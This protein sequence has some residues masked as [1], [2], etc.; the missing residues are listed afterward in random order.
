MN[1]RQTLA[2]RLAGQRLARQA[3]LRRLVTRPPRR[4]NPLGVF[5]CAA[6][7]CLLFASLALAGRGWH[8]PAPT[9]THPAPANAGHPAARLVVVTATHAPLES[10]DLRRVCTHTPAGRLH[11]RFEPG[12]RS[13][14]RGYLAEGETIWLDD[15]S[16]P[17]SLR[18]GSQWLHLAAPVAGWVN[19]RYVCTTE[20]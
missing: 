15:Q 8:A 7:L 18:D 9:Q 19:A 4:L 16:V 20:R 1:N 11:V 17:Q 10:V 12:E 13:E 3:R 2:A 5:L 14:V 6:G